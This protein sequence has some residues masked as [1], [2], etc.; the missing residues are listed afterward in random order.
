MQEE[1]EEGPVASDRPA[2][3][4]TSTGGLFDELDRQQRLNYLA[5][6]LVF[7]IDDGKGTELIFAGDGDPVAR[8]AAMNALIRNGGRPMGFIGVTPSTKFN[9]WPLPQYR[10]RKDVTGYL[11]KVERECRKEILMS[12]NLGEDQIIVTTT[13]Q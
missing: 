9:S 4:I 10:H 7:L 6:A 2:E 12:A 13:V 5:V 3:P 8:L 1:Q 11:D